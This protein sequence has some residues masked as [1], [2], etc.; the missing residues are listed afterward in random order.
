MRVLLVNPPVPLMYYNREFY[1]PSSLLY[2]G[3][4]LQKNGDEVSILDMKALKPLE[5]KN[6]IIFY[7]KTL[8]KTVNEFK[9]DLIGI[10]CLFSGNFLDVLHF[11]NLLKKNYNKIPIVIGGIHPTIYA[12][13]ILEEC[14]AIDWIVLGEGE[15]SF[16]RMVNAIKDKSYDFS[17]IDGFAYRKKG[18]VFLNPKTRFIEDLDSIPLPSYDLINIEDY[19]EDTSN[20]WNPKHLPINTSLPIISSRSCPNHCNFCSMF[21]VMGPHWRPRSPKNVVD[22]I[23]YLYNKY[24]HR[25]FSFM[26]DNFTLNRKRTIEICKEIINRELDIQFET[27]NGIS[28]NTLNQEVIDALVSAGMVRVY[29]AIE[30]GSEYIRN[31]VMGKNLSTEKIYEIVDL[32]KKYKQLYVKAFFIIGM[33]EETHETLEETYD[34]I[35]KI[36]VDRIY[37]H[38]VIPFPGTRVYEQALRDNLLIDLDPKK[39]YKSNELYIT[40]YERIFIKP[41][42]LELEDL[43]AFRKRCNELIEKQQKMRINKINV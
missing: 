18:K 19:Y 12:K 37:L 43:R 24:N 4:V 22:E 33:P 20:W 7:E 13:K 5:P 11:S 34:M 40:N 32:V 38:N 10:G 31:K 39:L 1:V 36:V 41:Y 26:D 27:P 16:I 15:E 6:P 17:E 23:E 8:I 9:P 30:S 42:K 21:M 3:A 2:L 35:K 25:H 14:L 29:L 28:I